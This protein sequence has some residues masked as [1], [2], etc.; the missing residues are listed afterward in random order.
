MMCAVH[1]EGQRFSELYVLSVSNSLA[2][3]AALLGKIHDIFI[4]H[5]LCT[6]RP[7]AVWNVKLYA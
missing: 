1:E 4:R 3:E 5:W 7:H 6:R 2:L